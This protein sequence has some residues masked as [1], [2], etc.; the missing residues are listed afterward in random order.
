MA[1]VHTQV[2]GGSIQEKE[3]TTV[4]ELKSLL[5]LTNYTATVNGDPASDDYELE[6]FEFVSFA[7]ATKGA[8][9]RKG[10][11]LAYR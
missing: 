11:A 3:A 10:G 6:D 1:K 7:L 2:T 4:G 5:G 8:I 9:L